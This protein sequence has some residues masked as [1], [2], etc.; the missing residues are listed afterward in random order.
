MRKPPLHQM[1]RGLFHSVVHRLWA[2]TCGEVVDSEGERGGC[3]QFVGG[4]VD[5]GTSLS[6]N[7]HAGDEQ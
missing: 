4:N 5:E 2:V 7:E 1:Q 3:P 6:S